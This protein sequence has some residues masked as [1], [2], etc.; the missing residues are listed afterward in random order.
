MQNKSFT[1]AKT[2]NALADIKPELDKYK[3]IIIFFSGA[4]QHN[5]PDISGKAVRIN[6]G[7]E[8]IYNL[9]T[10]CLAEIKALSLDFNFYQNFHK[11]FFDKLYTHIKL[12]KTAISNTNLSYI[13]DDAL[14]IYTN[15]IEK[16]KK[17]LNTFNNCLTDIDGLNDGLNARSAFI[18][19]ETKKFSG[20]E[21]LNKLKND[22]K[23]IQIDIQN[24]ENNYFSTS[25]ANYIKELNPILSFTEEKRSQLVSTIL[26][27]VSKNT[28]QAYSALIRKKIEKKQEIFNFKTRTDDWS[29]NVNWRLVVLYD[30]NE[31]HMVMQSLTDVIKGK[32]SSLSSGFKV[33]ETLF[34]NLKDRTS[35]I[36]KLDL[37][38]IED[39][40]IE[41]NIVEK[42]MEQLKEFA[43]KLTN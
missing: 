34:T 17:L 18:T 7:L 32:F 39:I 16:L 31:N 12:T 14:A 21:E 40:R 15:F 23:K 19:A 42:E 24:V 38:A 33:I 1:L 4:D 10:D 41:L 22:F 3:E 5:L 13:F 36:N 35:D 9:L 29:R 30:Y 28:F 11:N 6:H 2:L 37:K 20:F 26:E 25:S 8:S 43:S 27:T